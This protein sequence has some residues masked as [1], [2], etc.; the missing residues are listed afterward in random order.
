MQGWLYCFLLA[1]QIATSRPLAP[2]DDL[3]YHQTGQKPEAL[4][5]SLSSSMER[6]GATTK[7][8]NGER[9][10]RWELGR[11]LQTVNT[12]AMGAPRVKPF[13]R[14]LPQANESVWV[15]NMQI[16][17]PRVGNASVVRPFTAHELSHNRP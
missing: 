4:Q 11:V 12:N 17:N 16:M 8:E 9:G 2:N 6:A 13:K 15:C 14:L 3:G 1:L 7:E 5:V 10:V